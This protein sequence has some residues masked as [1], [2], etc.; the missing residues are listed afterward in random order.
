MVARDLGSCVCRRWLF[1]ASELIIEEMKG[2]TI[3]LE[4]LE[5][6]TMASALPGSSVKSWE[7]AVMVQATSTW[8]GCGGSLVL[9]PSPSTSFGQIS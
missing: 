8:N 3:G 1:E 5:G 4:S 6:L 7:E 2:L 9:G